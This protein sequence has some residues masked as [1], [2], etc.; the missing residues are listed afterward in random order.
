MSAHIIKFPT[1]APGPTKP[2]AKRT[3]AKNDLNDRNDRARYALLADKVCEARAGLKGIRGLFPDGT[4]E[5][6]CVDMAEAVL[7][8][9]SAL[10]YD[11]IYPDPKRQG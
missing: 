1:Q 11:K 9:L 10:A 3:V 6:T 4:A 2:K 5:R 8:H 7:I